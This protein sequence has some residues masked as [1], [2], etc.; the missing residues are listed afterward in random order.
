M[1]NMRVCALTMV[2]MTAAVAIAQKPEPVQLART[3]VD[4]LVKGEYAAVAAT[5]DEK[6]RALLNEDRLRAAWE[7]VV[8]QAGAFR[9]VGE[10][11]VGTKGDFTI[12]VFP[13]AFE[14]ASA[15][16]QIVVNP[17][18]QIAGLN[19]RPGAPAEAF[20]DAS[21]VDRT[22]FTERE[23]TIDAGGWPLP[24]TLALPN[25]NGP[26]P[27]VVLVHGSGPSDR[28]ETI[29]PN[30]PLRDLALGLASRA[31]ATLRYEKRTRQHGPKVASLT[32][33]TVKEETIDDAVA[34]ARMLR[35]T[36][37][38]DPA[39]VFALG[40]SLGG[41]LAPRIATAG[42]GDIR[43]LIIMAGA[44][45]SLEQSIVDQFRYLAMADGVVSPEEH[46]QIDE[47]QQLVELVKSMK[48]SDAPVTMGG[49]TIHRPGTILGKALEPLES[50]TGEVLTLLTLQ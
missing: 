38:I 24:G 43:G 40:H 46:K 50:G 34:A 29:G 21:Y 36:E 9:S 2:A 41:M 44:V 30:K 7:S 45:R 6:V 47:F 48:A 49:I 19:I 8:A 1:T 10:A 26:F 14:R 28:D 5:F 31:I 17:A 35:K 11:Q 32:Q 27:A 20:T 37:G 18:G 3:T 42:G 25:G 33:F 23:V 15:N 22:K 13:A 16:I 12:V 4:R 39:R